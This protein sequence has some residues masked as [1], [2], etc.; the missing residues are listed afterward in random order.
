M[1]TNS[2]GT[3]KFHA[4]NGKAQHALKVPWFSLLLS[5]GWGEDFFFVPNKFPL[6]SHQVPNLFPRFPMCS[7]SVLPIAP[8]FNPI[9]ST[10]SPPY[11]NHLHLS[12]VPMFHFCVA[13]NTYATYT[14]K[15]MHL[16]KLQHSSLPRYLGLTSTSKRVGVIP[17][18]DF[19]NGPKICCLKLPSPIFR[20]NRR[21][22]LLQRSRM[23]R[24]PPKAPFLKP[25]LTNTYV[26]REHIKLGIKPGPT[27]RL[28]TQA[29]TG[30]AIGATLWWSKLKLKL[31]EPPHLRVCL[32]EHVTPLLTYIVRPKGATIHLSIKSSILGHL[33]SFNL[34]WDGPIKLAHCKKKVGLMRHP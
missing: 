14:W 2:F 12:V 11:R 26:V 32:E 30:A 1:V 3:Q 13:L 8:R 23:M 7:P 17:V 27:F 15:T 28:V 22:H 24:S 5:F 16:V 20:L 18:V 9:C 21:L 4:T 25:S 6:G 19:S 31:C 29:T 10:Q 34:F 33:H